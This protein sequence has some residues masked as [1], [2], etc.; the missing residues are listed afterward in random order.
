MSSIFISHNHNDK[1]FVRELAAKLALF[2]I[3]A[4]V[5]E[6]EMLPG[7]SLIGKVQ[8][9]MQSCEYLGAVLSKN[10]VESAWVNREIS[11]ALAGEMEY[12]RVVVLPLLID[13]CKIPL[14]LR[15]KLFA[16]FR[17]DFYIGLAAILRRLLGSR[18][19][20]E[21]LEEDVQSY[22]TTRGIAI[23]QSAFLDHVRQQTERR[24]RAAEQVA[25]REFVTMAPIDAVVA[26]IGE[27]D[28][29][30]FQLLTHVFEMVS[31]C[32]SCGDPLRTEGTLHKHMSQERVQAIYHVVIRSPHEI[33]D[34][35]GEYLREIE[36]VGT[37]SVGLNCSNCAYRSRITTMD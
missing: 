14:F 6:F 26:R 21:F 7:D 20:Q 4:W 8:E 18:F 27:S 16:D 36:G 37:F 15:D 1:P 23:S 30:F 19:T 35:D 31:P 11:A 25:V 10:S 24:E 5:D 32:A 28:P 33:Y 12:Q 3:K 34:H 13:D 2:G 22:Y 9:G 17:T 29:K